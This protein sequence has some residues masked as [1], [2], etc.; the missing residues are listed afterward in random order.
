MEA[1]PAQRDSIMTRARDVREQACRRADFAELAREHSEDPGSAQQGGDLD[2]FGRGQMVVPFEEAAFALQAGEI[3][4][5]VESPFG[6]HI[7]KVE[8]KRVTAVRGRQREM[9]RQFAQQQRVGEAEEAYVRSLTE[10]LHPGAGRRD[11]GGQG[12]GR[13]PLTTARARREPGARPLPGRHAHGGGVPRPD[14]LELAA[15][16]AGAAGGRDGRPDR[17]RCCRG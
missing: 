8:D 15:A 5:V 2:Y 7:I 9:Y 11:R 14:A 6:L 13:K 16:A 12:A 1:T 17:A 10:P 4:E 3:S